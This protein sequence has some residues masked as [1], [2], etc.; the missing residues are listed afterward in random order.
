MNHPHFRDGRRYG[1]PWGGALGATPGLGYIAAVLQTSGYEV[2]LMDGYFM[3][4][5]Q[6]E[7][8]IRDFAPDIL[9]A[10]CMTIGRSNARQLVQLAKKIKPSLITIMGGPHPTHC[11]EQVLKDWPIDFIVMGEGEETIIDL[12]QT[13]EKKS[14]DF[15]S[16]KG[17]AF[18]KNGEVIKTE[19]RPIIKE[20]DK[21]R[22]P[23][24]E[25]Y[26]WDLYPKPPFTSF[27]DVRF[28][29]KDLSELRYSHMIT[30]RGC[31]YDCQFCSATKFWGKRW[32]FRS[33]DNILDEMELL[34]HKYKVRYFDFCDD[35]FSINKKRIIEICKGIL[36]RKLEIMFDCCTRADYVDREM[37]KWLYN[38]GCLYVAIG[39]ESG[40]EVI[41]N[42]INKKVSLDKIKEAFYILESEKLKTMPLIMVGNP[43]ECKETINET[44]KFLKEIKAHSASVVVAIIL[45]GTDLF[46]H[47]ESLGFISE[48]FWNTE[49]PAALYTAEHSLAQLF[50]WRN[51]IWINMPL[52]K[53]WQFKKRIGFRLKALKDVFTA[54]TGLYI[55]RKG[56]ERFRAYKYRGMR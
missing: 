53:T 38:A 55:N 11:Y 7:K 22:F 35:A 42:N 10:G 50:F 27:K 13:I 19:P 14:R 37:S 31:P 51:K 39:V 17:I 30:S 47:A 23:L 43:G 25:Q 21:I 3:D 24:Y 49:V 46:K 4:W 1:L 20:L 28:K 12:V 56:F 5:Q 32:R 33:A 40:S 2:K 34:Y 52:F 54:K 9:G 16:V 29:G 48:D 36:D 45:P 26:N 41:L 15:K 44:I 18:T 6:I 8:T